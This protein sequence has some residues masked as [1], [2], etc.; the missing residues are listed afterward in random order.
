MNR[1]DLILAGLASLPV[2]TVFSI[3]PVGAQRRRTPRH[4]QASLA[5][6]ARRRG[7]GLTANHVRT[8]ILTRSF[9]SNVPIAIPGTGTAAGPASPYPSTI[10]VGGFNRGRILKVRATLI[11]LSH[12]FPQEVDILLVAPGNVGVMLM[13]DAGSS[14]DV[15]NITLVFD[16]DALG[17]LPTPLVSGVYQPSNYFTAP[18]PLPP[19]APAGVTG[20][21][22]TRFNNRNPNGP[23]QLFVF[24]EVS[25][26]TGSLAGWSLTIQAR[27]PVRH[28]HRRRPSRKAGR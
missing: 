9:T 14:L 2:A 1:R 27:V 21:S 24:D 19:P 26:D 18:D 3:A 22:L 17:T 11:G 16:Q 20:H 13:S 28:R 4:R 23:W 25:G 10:Q 8:R 5:K 7:G 15:T 12:A 6:P